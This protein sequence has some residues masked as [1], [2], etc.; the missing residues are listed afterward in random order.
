MERAAL[1]IQALVDQWPA[2]DPKEGGAIVGERIQYVYQ[3]WYPPLWNLRRELGMSFLKRVDMNRS[4]N[5]M[6]LK[7]RF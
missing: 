2:V 5:L 1:Q 3:L 4:G 6:E 7:K